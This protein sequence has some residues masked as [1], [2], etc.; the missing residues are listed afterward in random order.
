MTIG[1]AGFARGSR[2]ALERTPP[3]LEEWY[4]LS[5]NGPVSTREGVEEGVALIGEVASDS[6]FA[7]GDLRG[8][9]IWI[10]GGAGFSWMYLATGLITDQGDRT[11]FPALCGLRLKAGNCSVLAGVPAGVLTGVLV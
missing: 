9:T 7:D 1:L 10:S 6:D 4:R 2:P 11:S 5:G 8:L 3:L